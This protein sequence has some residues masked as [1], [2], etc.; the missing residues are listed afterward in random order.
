M[1]RW[2]LRW[3]PKLTYMW[4]RRSVAQRPDSTKSA[5]DV[6]TE[7]LNRII[8]LKN[9]SRSYY[10]RD[11]SDDEGLRTF[12]VIDCSPIKRLARQELSRRKLKA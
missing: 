4:G 7:V 10:D 5:T 2:T 12:T 1:Q 6:P 11:L 8:E 3:L 9:T